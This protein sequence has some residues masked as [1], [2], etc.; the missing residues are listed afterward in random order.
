MG[1]HER[2]LSEQTDHF[3]GGVCVERFRPLGHRAD[4]HRGRPLSRVRG[5]GKGDSRGVSLGIRDNQPQTSSSREGAY[6]SAIVVDFILSVEI[7]VI[8]LGQVME[9]DLPVQIAAVSAIAILATVGVYGVLALLVRMDDAGLALMQRSSTYAQG[10]GRFLVAALPI[11]IK[12]LSVVGTAAL[13]LVSGGIFHHHIPGVHHMLQAWPGC[14]IDSMLGAG[15]GLVVWAVVSFM[16]TFGLDADFSGKGSTI[17][18]C[19]IVVSVR[20]LTMGTRG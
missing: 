11:L 8:A 16:K 2:I 5:G 7:V 12:A 3:A 1:H 14:V 15:F 19:P 4:P 13:L 17:H 6:R 10:L 9:A 20:R 18:A